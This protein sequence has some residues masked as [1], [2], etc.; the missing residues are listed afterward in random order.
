MKD[1]KFVIDKK[2]MSSNNVIC[3]WRVI[4]P[5][6]SHVELNITSLGLGYAPD[7]STDFVE[8]RDGH[9]EKSPLIGIY[10]L[11]YKFMSQASL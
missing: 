9:F 3:Q 2:S 11:Y 7:C 8:V 1:K 6:G 10:L 5:H 4:A